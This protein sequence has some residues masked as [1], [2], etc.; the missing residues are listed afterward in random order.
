M[1]VSWRQASYALLLCA[2]P[3]RF[4]HVP[5][6]AIPWT[7][8]HQA[9]LSLGFSR[10]EYWSGLP[11]PLLQGIFPTQWSNLHLLSLPLAPPDFLL[12]S[13]H[14]FQ[15]SFYSC[16]YR[17]FLCCLGPQITLNCRQMLLLSQRRLRSWM[18]SF[19]PQYIALGK[20][21][22]VVL[23]R[24]LRINILSSHTLQYT[25]GSSYLHFLYH[26]KLYTFS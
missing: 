14:Y 2:V 21:L 13:L 20:R 23:M 17:I 25:D 3:S 24:C 26:L 15:R 12:F 22:V 18:D 6:C 9:L 19:P 7:A 4:S 1:P 5:L 16:S 10:Q 8:T 11:C